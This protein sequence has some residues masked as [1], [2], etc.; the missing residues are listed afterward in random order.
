MKLVW[1]TKAKST[2]Y[3]TLLHIHAEFGYR[4]A[5]TSRKET[6]KASKQIVKFPQ[7]GPIEPLLQ[8]AEFEFRSVF[9]GTYNKLIYYI[10]EESIYITDVWDTRR[11]PEA[12][13]N[14]TKEIR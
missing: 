14:E 8:P 4:A 10:S 2:W 12:Q 6:S 13:A 7:S 9:C 11:E 3:R 5:L 1:Y